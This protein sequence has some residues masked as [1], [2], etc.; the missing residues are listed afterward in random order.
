MK[1]A[2]FG[3]IPNS[4]FLA[5]LWKDERLEWSPEEY[6]GLSKLNVPKRYVW[7]PDMMQ[8]TP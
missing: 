7:T 8:Y 3:T 1:I 2:D 6:G 5:Q 4:V